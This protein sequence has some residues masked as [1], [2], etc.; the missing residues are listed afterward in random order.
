MAKKKPKSIRK[1][2][3]AGMI[4]NG[5]E[6]YDYALY[7]SFSALIS[8]LFFPASNPFVSLLLT[9]GVFASGFVMRPVGALLFGYI[10][11]KYGR[12]ASLAISI[13][14]MAIPTAFMGLLPTYAQ[15]G[16]AA[17]IMLTILRLAQG[18]ALGGEFSGCITYLVE[19]SNK[20]NRNFVG[21]LS[22]ISLV[23]GVLFGMATATF[24][25][26]ILDKEDLESWGWRIPFIIGFFIGLVG[27]FIRSRLSESPEYENAKEFNQLAEKPVRELFSKHRR[28]ILL[29]SGLYMAVTIPFYMLTVFMNSFMSKILAY[30]LSET[31]LLTT[32]GMIVML[33]FMP[34][35]SILSDKFGNRPVMTISAALLAVAAFPV[36]W[37]IT[38]QDFVL[39]LIGIIFF[40]T[41]LSFYIAPIPTAL[42]DLFPTR[43]RYTGMAVACNLC[44][45]VF[46]GTTPIVATKLIQTT[47]NN[48][49]L[50]FYIMA[51]ALISLASLAYLKHKKI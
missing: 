16:L 14:M 13:L 2:A 36:F 32:I 12:K 44:A 17:P 51:A 7:G 1:V 34:I 19:H 37:L 10:G 20:K 25:S 15:I 39:A 45:T 26:N 4:G 46:G 27:L 31:M 28:A 22:V 18:L 11:D 5:L 24:F 35:S 49:I 42:V 47:G 30:S 40:A 50:A 3:L 41:V 29:S 48:M 21:S 9:Y 8:Q 38:Q 6:W 23:M 33:I 43:V